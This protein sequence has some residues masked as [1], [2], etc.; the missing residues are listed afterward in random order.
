[1]KKVTPDLLAIPGVGT[2]TAVALLEAAWDKPTG[3]LAGPRSRTCSRPRRGPLPRAGRPV[4]VRRKSYAPTRAYVAR[5]VMG[6]TLLGPPIE[7][8]V[9]ADP[10]TV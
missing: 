2:E 5:E 10:K 1:V 7:L 3:W 6:F 8:V 4:L 9:D